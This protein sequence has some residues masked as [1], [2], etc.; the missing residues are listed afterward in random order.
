MMWHEVQV[1]AV[2][3]DAMESDIP[4]ERLPIDGVA[5]EDIPLHPETL[6]PEP[7]HPEPLHP[8]QPTCSKDCPT[9]ITEADRGDFEIDTDPFPNT[10][11]DDGVPV[12]PWPKRGRRLKV[13]HRFR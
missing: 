5:T 2:V 1:Q 10:L 9:D 3:D 7:L 4:Q 8:E 12:Y 13:P 6:H 11:E